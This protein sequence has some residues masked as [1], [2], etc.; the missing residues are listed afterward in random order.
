MPMTR[1]LVVD[2]NDAVREMTQEVFESKGFEV[3]P[4]GSVNDALKQIVVQK[5]DVLVTDLHMPSPG[6]GY[7]VVTAMRHAQPNAL[8]ILVS[9]Y[10]DIEGA[11]AAIALQADQVL[12]K[13]LEFAILCELIRTRVGN[14]DRASHPL[15]L[16]HI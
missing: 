1:I 3:V 4:V 9:G 11:M 14:C 6:D 12:A 13:P 10:P 8:K 7:A 16:I 2:D 15:S 5:F